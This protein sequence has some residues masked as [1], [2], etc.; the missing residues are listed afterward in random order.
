MATRS[1]IGMVKEDKS[2]EIIY[3]HWDGYP[4]YVGLQLMLN[5]RDTETIQKLI[6]LGDRSTLT[7][8]PTIEST[9]AELQNQEI[10]PWI[11]TSFE[12]F[13]NADKAG[14]DYVYIWN[15]EWQVFKA[16]YDNNL[17]DI[18]TIES[19]KIEFAALQGSI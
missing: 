8:S 1:L 16:D 3:C 19:I 14:A 10:K 18:G 5:Y 6:A 12:E 2:I 9:Y 17:I 11:V 13:K 15:N 7:G 4:E